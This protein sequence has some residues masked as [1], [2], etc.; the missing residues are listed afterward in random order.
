MRCELAWLAEWAAPL[1]P[2]AELAARLTAAGLEAAAGEPGLLELDLTPNR[3]DCLSVRGL[4]REAAAL[5]GAAYREPPAP[6]GA[7]DPRTPPPALG[8]VD[9]AGC[10]G[11]ALRRLEGLDPAARTPDWMAARL[12]RAGVRGHAFLVDVTNYVMLELGQPLH[13]FDAARVAG[14]VSV[15]PARPGERLAALAGGE[16]ELAEDM[17]VIA[18]E[19][20]ALAV[21]GVVGGADSAVGEGTAAALLEAALFAPA[22]VAGRARRLKLHTE[23]AHRFERGV[24]PGLALRALRRASALI[25]E[26]AGGRASPIACRGRTG[27]PPPVPVRLRAA[28]LHACLGY[29]PKAAEV[30]SALAALGCRPRAAADGWTAAPP[31]WR[32]DLALEADLVEEVARVLG[33]DRIPCAAPRPPAAWRN[34]ERP[35]TARFWR[36]RDRLAERGWSEAV[37]YSFTEERLERLFAPGAEPLRLKNP[38]AAEQAVLRTTLCPSLLR[39]AQ[40]NVNRRAP[41]VR[42]FEI[43]RVYA[44]GGGGGAAEERWALAGVA[45]GAAHPAQWGVRGAPRALDF[46]DVKGDLESLF[47]AQAPA[48]SFAPIAHPALHPGRAARIALDGQA[49]GVAGA[50]HPELA[51]EFDLEDAYLFE[52]ELEAWPEAPPERF[53]PWSEYPEIARDLALLVAEDVSAAALEDCVRGLGIETLRTLTVFDVYRGPDLGGGRKSVGLRLIFQSLSGTLC[54][55]DVDGRV[56]GI[57]AELSER[58]GAELRA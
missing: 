54:D 24:E 41:G 13:A 36:C 44:P 52:L 19:T 58:L 16:L 55:D 5:T 21:A 4:A 6:G 23:A 30:T 20:R 40:Y 27:P 12:E 38:L 35:W 45:A 33:Y 29:A 14:A 56:A 53:A 9:A 25:L 51:A 7:L 43:A 17:L 31:P 57:V 2:P 50:L 49:L 11:Y 1:P 3:G 39:A 26:H 15:R 18:D 42:L 46:Y 47:G 8:A 28:R 32:Y 10:P 48:L 37:T 34:P 22:A